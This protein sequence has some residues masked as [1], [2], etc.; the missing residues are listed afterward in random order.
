[1]EIQGSTSKKNRYPEW[2]LTFILPVSDYELNL[3]NLID[4]RNVR[5][6]ILTTLEFWSRTPYTLCICLIYCVIRAF[7]GLSLQEWIKLCKISL[8]FHSINQ[9]CYEHTFLNKIFFNNCKIKYQTY[10]MKKKYSRKNK[11]MLKI[12]A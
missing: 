7:V 6:N 8:T 12:I 9:K 11:K 10:M 2:K 4:S 3:N 5:S 1:M